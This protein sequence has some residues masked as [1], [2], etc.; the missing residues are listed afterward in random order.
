MNLSKLWHARKASYLRILQG[1][2]MTCKS[3]NGPCG[4]NVGR[5]V[6]RFF[7]GNSLRNHYW[8]R[9]GWHLIGGYSHGSLVDR[10]GSGKR[11]S[12]ANASDHEWEIDYSG[13]NDRSLS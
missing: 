7:Y 11:R 9:V 5:I 4:R 13:G 1:N 2:Q 12:K 10:Y 3:S 8:N 6:G